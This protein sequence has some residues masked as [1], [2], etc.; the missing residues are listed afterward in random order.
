MDALR[1]YPN[2]R[3][4]LIW[5][6][7]FALAGCAGTPKDAPPEEISKFRRGPGSVPATD[8]LLL[9]K[10]LSGWNER[11]LQG[12]DELAKSLGTTSYMVIHRGELVHEFGP[13]SA[14]SLLHSAR[15]GVMALLYGFAVDRG[16]INVDTTMAQLGMVDREKLTAQ[17]LRAT[18][19]NL[20]QSRSGIYLP[21]AAETI[22]MGATRPA[23][24]S[25]LPGT[26]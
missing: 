15:K 26:C 18:I 11:L 19:K 5:T 7:G 8:W 13:T 12:A 1:Q 2:R 4:A 25:H 14:P 9:P 24:G 3:D 20:L 23:R 21:A 16:K 17:E 10:A 22:N 6:A